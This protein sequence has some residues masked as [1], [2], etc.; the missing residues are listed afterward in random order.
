ME[1]ELKCGDIVYVTKKNDNGWY[2]GTLESN[3]KVG[4]FPRSFVQKI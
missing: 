4:L 3:G 1:L 2:Y